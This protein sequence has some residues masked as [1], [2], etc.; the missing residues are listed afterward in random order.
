MFNRLGVLAMQ[1]GIGALDLIVIVVYLVGIVG[2]GCWVG[3]RH[4]R[5]GGESKDYFLA[6]GT[7]TWPVIG[8]ALFS[9]NISTVH[10]V[11][12]AQEGYANGLAFGNFELMAGFT[13]ILLALFFAPFYIRSRVAT[14][15]DFLE[16]RYSRASRDWLAFISIVS[17]IFIHIGFT[18]YTAALV[19]HGLLGIPEEYLLWTIIAIAGMTGLYTAVGGLIAVV[20][21]EAIQTVVLLLG[22]VCVTVIALI[23]SGGWSGIRETLVANDELAKLSMLRSADDPAGLP[24]YAVFLG[25]PVIG[26]WYWCTDQTIVQRVLGAKSEDHARTGALFAGFIKILPVFILVLP[27]LMC[28]V[29]VLQ[30]A[31]DGQAPP[32]SKDAYSFM[33]EQIMPPGLRGVVAAALLA[34]AMSTVS[35]ALNSVATLFSYDLFKRWVPNISE[36]RL[37]VI[38]R[39]VTVVGM[40]VAVSWSPFIS[41]FESIF[42]MMATMICYIAPPITATF[43]LGVFWK[44]ASSKGSIATL[45]G[46]FVL[47]V[48]AFVV[49]LSGTESME[50]LHGLHDGLINLLGG[51][52]LAETVV[53]MHWMVASFWL[54]MLCMAFHV[55][56]S[57]ATPEE[58]TEQKAAL[59]WAHPL[60]ALRSPGWTGIGNYKILSA[61]LFGTLVVLYVVLG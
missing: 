29:L 15:P 55:V 11:S 38:G 28:Y 26:I 54:C 33:I 31:F 4:R 60:D 1:F 58:L 27:G 20:T 37:V 61:V 43:V 40:I 14:L 7:L 12:L 5:Q 21:T 30:N 22:A 10:L 49:N 48:L 32:E 24:W 9:T 47:G 53:N 45:I 51:G 50:S 8:L 25:Y 39:C 57:L 34:A 42:G 3:L 19:M 35:G 52:S 41:Q 44:G 18:L 36:H 2:L 23:E 17:A 13:L 6:G 59:V 16:R 56:V 46:G